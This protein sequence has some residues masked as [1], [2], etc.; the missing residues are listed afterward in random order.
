MDLKKDETKEIEYET[1]IVGAL[2]KFNMI[3]NFDFSLLAR[4][5]IKE[6][7]IKYTGLW[8]ESCCKK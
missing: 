1:F 6:C 4:D 8:Y 2:L 7:D 3:D 5:F